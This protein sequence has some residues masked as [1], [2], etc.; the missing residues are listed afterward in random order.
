MTTPTLFE[1]MPTSKKHRGKGKRGGEVIHVAFGPGGGRIHNAET[2]APT[3][4]SNTQ[5]EVP[6]PPSTREP[7]TDVFSP[8]EVAKLL[9]VTV[10]RL[11]S[12]DR[13]QVVSPSAM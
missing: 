1:G 10:A 5:P 9:G 11:R 7:V 13:S 8:R 6:P 12:L 2:K 3:R 4:S